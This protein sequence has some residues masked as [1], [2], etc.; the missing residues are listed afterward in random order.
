MRLPLARRGDPVQALDK[1]FR[2][3]TI[4]LTTLK[5]ISLDSAEP[6]AVT[7]RAAEA[8]VKVLVAVAPRRLCASHRSRA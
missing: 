4:A 6:D 2:S 3:G 5:A 8:V 1:L 7:S